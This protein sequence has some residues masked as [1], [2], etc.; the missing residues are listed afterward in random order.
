MLFDRRYRP[1]TPPPADFEDQGAVSVYSTD[2][3]EE[4]ERERTRKTSLGKRA[5][6]RLEA[7]LRSLTS[8]REKIARPMAFALERAEAADEV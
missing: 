8:V 2:S 3:A 6:K 1:P 5:R 7:M 4:S